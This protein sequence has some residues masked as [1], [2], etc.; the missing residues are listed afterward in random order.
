MHKRIPVLEMDLDDETGSVKRIGTLYAGDHLPIG[1]TEK[2][3]A[4][5]RQAL[6][7]WW[8]DR[9]IPASRSGVRRA[10]ETLQAASTKMLLVRCCGLSLSDQYWICPE[11]SD[12]CW[13]EINFFDHDFSA[14]NRMSPISSEKS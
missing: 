4:A 7:E 13:D 1:I 2:N 14:P 5:D 10:L 12:L 6:N 9:A 3:G 8:T 11:H